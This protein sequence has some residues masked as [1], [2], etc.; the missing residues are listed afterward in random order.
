MKSEFK[1][2]GFSKQRKLVGFLQLVGG[3]GLFI[4]LKINLLLI[5][6]SLC[7]IIMMSSAI[8]I[9]IKIKDNITDILPAITYL[10]LSILIFIDS[11]N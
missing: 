1:R 3:L 7:F 6:T 10:F 8:I 4:G 9:R 11:I 5:L 2:W